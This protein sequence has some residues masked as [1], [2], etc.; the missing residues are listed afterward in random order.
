MERAAK[1]LRSGKTEW[2][3]YLIRTGAEDVRYKLKELRDESAG[4]LEE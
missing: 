3:L 1:A 4:L 2:A